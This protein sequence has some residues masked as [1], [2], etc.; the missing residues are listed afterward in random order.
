MLLSRFSDSFS[1]FEVFSIEF[2]DSRQ[3]RTCQSA[4]LMRFN[5]K[6][7][8]FQRYSPRFSLLY[9]VN[10]VGFQ[11]NLRWHLDLVTARIRWKKSIFETSDNQHNWDK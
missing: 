1:G 6:Y 7:R 9:L 11:L 5:G 10:L 3:F 8:F 4:F 2:D